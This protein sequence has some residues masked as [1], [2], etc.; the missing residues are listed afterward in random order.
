MKLSVGKDNSTFIPVEVTDD[1]LP[2]IITQN[3]YSLSTFKNN[4]RTNV[5]FSGTHY[6]GLDFDDGMTIDEAKKVFKDYKHLIG[7]TKSHRKL[8]N[9]VVAD[10]FRV[11]LFLSKAITDRKVYTA[12]MADLLS[13]FPQ[14]DRAC[15]DPARMF[16]SCTLVD[17]Y[18]KSGKLIDPMPADKLAEL[19]RQKI[20]LKGKGRLLRAT[21]DFIMF[22]TDQNWNHRLYAASKDLQQNGYTHEE[23]L[24]LLTLATL[25][26]DGKLQA[27][28]K[29]SIK[30]AFDSPP[31]DS[32]RNDNAFNFRN[33]KELYEQ[34][35][36]INWLVDGLLCEGGISLIA[37]QPKSGKS[38]I[39]RQLCATIA[40]GGTFLGREVKQG[41]IVYLALEEQDT[42]IY[43][44][45]KALGVEET[46]PILFHAGPMYKQ[47]GHEDFK[48]Y[49]E[50]N[51][52]SIAVIDTIALFARLQDDN[53]YKEVYGV[54]SKYR[55]LARNTGTHIICIHH[56]RKPYGNERGIN[57][58]MGSTA[59]TGAVDAIVFFENVGG[60]R[61]IS[62]QGRG[63]RDFNRQP[64]EFDEATQT[65][66]EG[67]EDGF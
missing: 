26:Y 12:T 41:S 13:R 27:E 32:P 7:P 11:I 67:V 49:L 40:K 56:Q 59:F 24:E 51:K 21:T 46:D 61:Y 15:K 19:P 54:L 23:A 1:T 14:A 30:S 35:P 44:Q 45:F 31:N 20:E 62:S 50:A 38:T 10:R 29:K 64:L 55:D 60:K 42:M 25:R 34:K 2:D 5:N 6:L 17:E 3:T 57:T 4:H 33:L 28:D 43:K 8:K 65:Y 58:V 48:E 63:T 66:I 9:G 53:N 37:G 36:E 52:P 47:D 18:V 16:F 22:G 39:T